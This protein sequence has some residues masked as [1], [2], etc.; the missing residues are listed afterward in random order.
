MFK[1]Q[2]KEGHCLGM[3][4]SPGNNLSE[5]LEVC[6]NLEITNIEIRTK[7]DPDVRPYVHNLDIKWKEI[8]LPPEFNYTLQLLRKALVDRLNILKNIGVLDSAS[9]ALINRK[10][11]LDVQ[12]KIQ[13]ALRN[14]PQPSQTLFQ[15]ASAQNACNETCSC[16]RTSSNTRGE[17]IE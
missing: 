16:D 3:T 17:R 5:I 12:Q 15:A 7:V 4:A 1:K 11:L 13:S 2:Q 8:P 14:T 10:K 9:V 6:K